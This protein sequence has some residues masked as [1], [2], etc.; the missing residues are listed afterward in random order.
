MKSWRQSTIG[1]PKGLRQP[2]LKAA[3]WLL[4]R[5]RPS[6]RQEAA[7]GTLAFPFASASSQSGCC[8]AAAQA[9]EAAAREV[10]LKAVFYAALAKPALVK[11]PAAQPGRISS[12]FPEIAQMRDRADRDRPLCDLHPQG[13]AEQR[14]TKLAIESPRDRCAASVDFRLARWPFVN[15]RS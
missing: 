5:L 2:T 8:L 9:A 3:E 10:A 15:T 4:D 14:A 6:Q 1:S 11:A 12:A 7:V 13:I